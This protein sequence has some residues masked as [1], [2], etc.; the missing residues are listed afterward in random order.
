M[1]KSH[2]SVELCWTIYDIICRYC[3]T[4]QSYFMN[5]LC[6]KLKREKKNQELFGLTPN[7]LISWMN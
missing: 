6:L 2:F 7:K 1:S 4:L 5:Y 3:C